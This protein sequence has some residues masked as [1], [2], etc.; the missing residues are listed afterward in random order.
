MARQVTAAFHAHPNWLQVSFLEREYVVVAHHDAERI[1]PE[2]RH[3][4]CGD[5]AARRKNRIALISTHP[6]KLRKM[7]QPPACAPQN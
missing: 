5:G 4:H 2:D 7:H 6:G 3:A 1:V